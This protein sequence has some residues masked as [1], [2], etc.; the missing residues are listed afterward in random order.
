MKTPSLNEKQKLVSEPEADVTRKEKAR[1]PESAKAKV[2]D[3][4]LSRVADTE[5]A[6]IVL[7]DITGWT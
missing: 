3:D 5:S 7:T 1:L 4:F 6:T 2:Y